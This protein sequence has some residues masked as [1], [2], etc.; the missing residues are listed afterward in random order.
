MCSVYLL[1]K[2]VSFQFCSCKNSSKRNANGRKRLGCPC[3]GAQMYEWLFMWTKAGW[4]NK[5]QQGTVAATNAGRNAFERHQ[6]ASSLAIN[7]HICNMFPVVLITWSSCVDY[8]ILTQT[9]KYTKLGKHYSQ[10]LNIFKNSLELWQ[11]AKRIRY[12]L[13]FCQ[14]MVKV[15][16]IMPN[17]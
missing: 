15:G 7:L 11:L 10:E 12:C 13:N 16:L 9:Q 2:S 17:V 4:K 3:R 14:I 6:I 8:L 1:I 5:L